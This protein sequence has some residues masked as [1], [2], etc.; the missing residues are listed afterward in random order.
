MKE[1]E[2]LTE[3]HSKFKRILLSELLIAGN[4]K[5]RNAFNE[6]KFVKINLV[7]KLKTDKCD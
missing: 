4:K 3:N 5:K 2:N 1:K 6:N 7:K